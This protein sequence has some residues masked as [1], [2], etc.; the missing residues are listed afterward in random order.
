MKE[1]AIPSRTEW[2]LLSRNGIKRARS[3]S[4]G[5]SSDLEGRYEGRSRIISYQNQKAMLGATR[6]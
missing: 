1:S 3:S 5:S 2:I 4:H 6:V